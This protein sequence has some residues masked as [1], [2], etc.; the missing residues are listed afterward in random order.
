ME[1]LYINMF[2]L[3]SNANDTKFKDVLLITD[4]ALKYTFLILCFIKA[5]GEIANHLLSIFFRF[6]ILRKLSSDNE[7]KFIN[8][9]VEWTK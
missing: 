8:K 6:G 1:H 5:M 3:S 7:T 2:T 9:V 4:I